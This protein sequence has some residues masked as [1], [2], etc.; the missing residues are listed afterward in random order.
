MATLYNLLTIDERDELNC[1]TYFGGKIELDKNIKDV[2]VE[3]LSRIS[4]TL[5]KTEYK[6]KVPECVLSAKAIEILTLRA[7]EH[8]ISIF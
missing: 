1:T 8:N 3:E 6:G 5:I 4:L 2:T 7:I